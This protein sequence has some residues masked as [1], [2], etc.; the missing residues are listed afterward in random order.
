MFATTAW[1]NQYR[2]VAPAWNGLPSLV[3]STTPPK[4]L[5]VFAVTLPASTGVTSVTVTFFRTWDDGATSQEIVG[6]ASVYYVGSSDPLPSYQAVAGDIGYSVFARLQADVASLPILT[7]PLSAEIE[8]DVVVIT[9]PT[10]D[11]SKITVLQRDWN[12]TTSVGRSSFTIASDMPAFTAGWDLM[13]ARQSTSTPQPSFAKTIA[14]LSGVA[15]TTRPLTWNPQNGQTAGA[16][17]YFFMWWK[18]TGS[19][20]LYPVQYVPEGETEPEPFSFQVVMKDTSPP[21]GD[22]GDFGAA[23]LTL[24]SATQTALIDAIN[25]RIAANNAATYTIDLP[26]GNYAL[27]NLA[28]KK[29]IGRIVLR[30]QGLNYG[31][32]FTGANLNGASNFYFQFVKFDRTAL[33]DRNANCV[34]MS[35]SGA[36][37]GNGFEYCWFQFAAA[38]ADTGVAWL[39]TANYGINLGYTAPASTGLRVYM[40]SFEGCAQHHIYLGTSSNNYVAENV[41]AD[42][43]ADDIECGLQTNTTILN[44]WGSRRHFLGF[45][46]GQWTHPDFIQLTASV[47]CDNVTIE[48]NVMMKAAWTRNTATPMQGIFGGPIAMTNA[49]L[50]D[51]IILTNSMNGIVFDTA[52]NTFSG[53]RT[54]SN[55]CIKLVDDFT[56]PDV[57]Q[58]FLKLM[59]TASYSN[60]Y[61]CV[62]AGNLT[63]GASGLAEGQTL[64]AI[65]NTNDYTASLTYYTN[66]RMGATFYGLRPVAGQPTHWAYQGVRKGAWRR[67]RAVL[68]NGAWPQI[69]RAATAFRTW[70]DPNDER[71]SWGSPWT[72]AGAAANTVA[73]PAHRAPNGAAK[74][75]I[76]GVALRTGSTTPPTLPSGQGWTDGGTFTSTTASGRWFWKYATTSSEAFGTA[77]NADRVVCFTARLLNAPA[78]PIGGSGS[79]STPN[80]NTTATWSAVASWESANSKALSVMLSLA[81]T[82]VSDRSDPEFFGGVGTGAGRVRWCVSNGRVSSWLAFVG[83]TGANSE[84]LSFALE[85]R[86]T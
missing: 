66:P 20:T 84:T 5:T 24:A 14:E 52:G 57:K 12:G 86:S 71:S 50:K 82:S 3:A 81:D 78:D 22:S 32:V 76:V 56:F 31:A 2:S 9:P 34:E 45:G 36:S 77:T 48:G 85:V 62:T 27:P 4:P 7:T 59:G 54:D 46:G 53:N 6:S 63:H 70:Y 26:P 61:M 68:E 49:L 37:G 72:A 67:F 43:Q 11:T 79:S 25:A 64:Y 40:C 73:I 18:Q 58:C 75:I 13:V 55:S 47:P 15:Q 65:M 8:D 44:N 21:P 10:L 74:S 51:N 23:D 39:A 29:P 30:S 1:L 38:V 16:T 60:N 83:A 19:P 17:D 69:G 41:F 42:S 35:N 28:N 33:P 80:T